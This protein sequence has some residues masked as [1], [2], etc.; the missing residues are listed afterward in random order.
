MRFTILILV[1][2]ALLPLTTHAAEGTLEEIVVT[3]LTYRF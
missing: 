2:F 3:D 1:G